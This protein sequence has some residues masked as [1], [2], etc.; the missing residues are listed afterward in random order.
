MKSYYSTDSPAEHISQTQAYSLQLS[1]ENNT[2]F[3]MYQ[4]RL[5]ISYCVFI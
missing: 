1:L 4:F 2:E 5:E 3:E